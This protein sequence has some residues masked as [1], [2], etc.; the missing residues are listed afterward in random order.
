MYKVAMTPERT[1]SVPLAQPQSP[2]KPFP[3]A[4]HHQPTTKGPQ[5]SQKPQEKK[6]P[7]ASQYSRYS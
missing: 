7:V 6:R 4:P 3:E 1:K 5:P 2:P